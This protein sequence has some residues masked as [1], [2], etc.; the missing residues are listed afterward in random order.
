MAWVDGQ[1]FG[2]DFSSSATDLRIINTST[3]SYSGTVG[4]MGYGNI[5]GMGYDEDAGRLWATQIED[6]SSHLIELDPVT[7]AGSYVGDMGIAGMAEID[8]HPDLGTMWAVHD[9]GSPWYDDNL[10]ALNPTTGMGTE[11]S[12]RM[13]EDGMR[14]MVIMQRTTPEPPEDPCPY[15]HATITSPA[16]VAT[17]EPCVELETVYLHITSGVEDVTLPNLEIVNDYIYF[18]ENA[19]TRTVSF[20]ALREVGGYLYFHNNDDIET[21]D[22]GVLESVGRYFYLND[23]DAVWELTGVDDLAYVGEYTHIVSNDDLCVP[24]LDWESFTVGSVDIYGNGWCEVDTSS[25]C[26]TGEAL[27]TG[28]VWTTEGGH[29]FTVPEAVTEVSV[30]MI[31]GGGGGGYGDMYVGGAGGSGYYLIEETVSVTPGDALSLSIGGGAAMGGTGGSTTFSTLSVSGG[32]PG[33]EH[34]AYSYETA[35][36]GGDGGSGGG[37][38]Y[39]YCEGGGDGSGVSMGVYAGAGGATSIGT[40]HGGSRGEGY[41]G[42]GGGDGGTSG[43]SGDCGGDGGSGGTSG[44][45]VGGCGGGGGGGG[46]MVFPDHTSPASGEDVSG[47]SGAVW[48]SW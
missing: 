34:H 40:P 7:G 37:A 25:I 43:Y 8:V 18:Y 6:G 12:W 36:V 9:V 23:N 41:G 24:D 2:V 5:R 33:A 20:P 31:G 15:D 17:Y 1:L 45:Y 44:T 10:V 3:G 16:D 39:C 4:A 21:I 14:G 19:D 48:V 26:P 38:G 13:A 42:G 32:L 29:S 27:G 35:S 30:T 28:C 11:E 47:M 22:L 46:G